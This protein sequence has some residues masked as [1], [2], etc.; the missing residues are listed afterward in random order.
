MGVLIET[1]LKRGGYKHVLG[2]VPRGRHVRPPSAMA[3]FLLLTVRAT[4]AW[5][6]RVERL[7][8]PGQ[9]EDDSDDRVRRA[10]DGVRDKAKVGSQLRAQ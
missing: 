4:R 10:G 8:V 1:N 9:P 5:G 3:A 7:H 2:V 6:W